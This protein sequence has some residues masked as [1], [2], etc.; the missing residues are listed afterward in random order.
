MYYGKLT[1]A[2]SSSLGRDGT[3]EK[4]HDNHLQILDLIENARGDT[5]QGL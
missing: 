2:L 1:F 5:F 3:A 4:H